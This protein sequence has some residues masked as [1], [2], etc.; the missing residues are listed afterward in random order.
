MLSASSQFQADI[1]SG[2]VNDDYGVDTEISATYCYEEG[3]IVPE[4]EL[5]L[6]GPELEHIQNN[7]N[8]LQRSDNDGVD[9]YKQV[10]ELPF[11][12]VNHQ[13]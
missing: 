13:W 4:I 6:S 7:Y 1:A 9:I 3:V 8:P 5:D 12:F 10:K 2:L 11:K